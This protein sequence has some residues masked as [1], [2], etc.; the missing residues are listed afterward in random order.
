MKRLFILAIAIAITL[1]FTNVEMLAQS[2]ETTL[3]LKIVQQPVGGMQ[4]K[5]V[6]ITIAGKIDG[7]AKP[8]DVTILWY[9]ESKTNTGMELAKTENCTFWDKNSTNII[10]KCDMVN[11][12]P[13]ST[14]YYWAVLN[15]TDSNG[16]HKLETQKVLSSKEKGY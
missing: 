14:F 4:Q 8:V 15:W 6:Y 13:E 12:Y 10:S 2:Q 11:A 5:Y 9:K 3:S 7:K 16:S 1:C